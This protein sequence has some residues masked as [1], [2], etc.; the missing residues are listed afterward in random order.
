MCYDNLVLDDMPPEDVK[1]FE[2]NLEDSGI[3]IVHR[4]YGA[5]RDG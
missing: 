4:H 2:S 5:G 3:E 1:L